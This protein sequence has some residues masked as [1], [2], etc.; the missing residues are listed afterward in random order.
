MDYGLALIYEE[1]LTIKNHKKNYKYTY[2]KTI[3]ASKHREQKFVF[4][5]MLLISAI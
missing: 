1:C 3:K 4:F 5:Y 2:V